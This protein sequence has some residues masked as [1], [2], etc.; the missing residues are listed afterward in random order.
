M[1]LFAALL[2]GGVAGQLLTL[3]FVELPEVVEIFEPREESYFSQEP[4]ILTVSS[5]GLLCDPNVKQYTGYFSIGG[6]N[7]KYFFWFFEARSN[8]SSAPTVAWLTGGP[9]CSSML[10]LFGENGP[11]STDGTSTTLNPNSWTNNANMFWIDQPPGTG[12]S[13]GDADSGEEEVSNDMLGFLRAFFQAMPQY[14]KNFYIFGE[15]YAGHYI[16][17]IAHK[18]FLHNKKGGDPNELIDFKGVGIGN[19]LTNPSEQ[20]KWYPTMAF[21]STTAP[22]VVTKDEFDAMEGSVESCVD[23]IDLCNSYD[24][25]NP[26]CLAA[27]LY[28]NLN[29]MQP[30]QAHGMNPYDMRLKCEN[31]PLCYD[32]AAIGQFLNRPEVQAVLGVRGTWSECNMEVNMQFVFDFMRN[33]QQ[34]VPDLLE[35]G[36]RVL[37]YAGDQ[38][39]ICNWLGNKAWVLDL[40]WSGKAG[41]NQAADVLYADAQGSAIGKLRSH[42]ALSFLQVFKAGHMVPMDQPEKSLHMF[43][44]FLKGALGAAEENEDQVIDLQIA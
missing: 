14:N 43:N 1:S 17:A 27:M 41:F 19:G 20:Y 24:G 8:P 7:K 23:L 40:D 34:L 15:S 4:S 32:F 37:V 42:K 22:Q 2:V 39:F 30:Y 11:C 6:T 16:P 33:Y 10:A 25:Q 12:F 44:Q 28:C 21:N 29:L 3:P 38:D 35:A 31:P 18:I 5:D 9:G 36:I 26:A 13:E